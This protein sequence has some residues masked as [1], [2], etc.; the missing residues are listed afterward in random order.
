VTQQAVPL[1]G[2]TVE[3]EIDGALA[4]QSIKTFIDPADIAALG[5]F[6]AGPAVRT[7]SGQ[8]F[9]I[10]GDFRAAM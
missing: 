10:D 3:E 9:P 4:N 1:L 5:L 6:L 8:V 2:R 7:I